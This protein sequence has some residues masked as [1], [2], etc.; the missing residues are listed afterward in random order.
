MSREAP[1]ELGRD[2]AESLVLALIASNNEENRDRGDDE[3][4]PQLM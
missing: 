3:F 2:L 1:L 4:P